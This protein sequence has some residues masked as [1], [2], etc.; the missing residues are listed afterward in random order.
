MYFLDDCSRIE[1]KEWGNLSVKQLFRVISSVCRKCEDSY[2]WRFFIFGWVWIWLNYTGSIMRN[3][4]FKLLYSKKCR[5]FTLGF[6]KNI[7][8]TYLYQKYETFSLWI[9][10]SLYRLRF[11]SGIVNYIFIFSFLT[12]FCDLVC[13]TVAIKANT[14]FII[15]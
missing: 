14:C 2:V 3:R 12:A 11:Y 7:K 8:L 10:F 15:Y 6:V 4:N 13:L 9:L 5:I 1:V